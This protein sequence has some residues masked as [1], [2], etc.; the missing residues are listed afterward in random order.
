MYV[1]CWVER[2]PYLITH[3][4]DPIG[5]RGTVRPV[6]TACGESGGG[7]GE[8]GSSTEIALVSGFDYDPY[9]PA[10]THTDGGGEDCGSEGGGGGGSTGTG[11]QYEPGDSTGGETVDWGTGVGNGGTSVCGQTAI[12]E[13]VC[14]DLW[15]DATGT[16]VEYSCGYATTC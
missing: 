15:D 12:V 6:S 2:N 1:H 5:Y 10:L 7:L 3:H 16:W 14:I 4:R 9:D 13:Y 8:W 11:T